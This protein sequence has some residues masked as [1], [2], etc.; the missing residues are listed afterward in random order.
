MPGGAGCQ[1]VVQKD[2]HQRLRLRHLVP[3]SILYL[4][5]SRAEA[6]Q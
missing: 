1:K 6:V 5:S 2:E 4:A 3:A